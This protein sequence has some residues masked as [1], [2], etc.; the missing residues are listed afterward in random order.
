MS[1]ARFADVGLPEDFHG[2]KRRPFSPFLSTW[3]R[4][5]PPHVVPGAPES[6]EVE[7]RIQRHFV[8]Q[9]KGG[10][11]TAQMEI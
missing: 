9:S 1:E 3:S 6:P 11:F 8:V 10:D 5:L 7:F 2:W 4:A